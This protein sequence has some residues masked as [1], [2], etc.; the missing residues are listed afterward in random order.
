[1][2]KISFLELFERANSNTDLYVCAAHKDWFD[3]VLIYSYQ[4]SFLH[5]STAFLLG[6][7]R[8][9][10]EYPYHIMELKSTT[11]TIYPTF[12]AFLLNQNKRISKMPEAYKSLQDN[13]VISTSSDLFVY[14]YKEY[15]CIIDK[16]SHVMQYDQR[17]EF[18]CINHNPTIKDWNLFESIDEALDS[19]TEINIEGNKKCRSQ[20][21]KKS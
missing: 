9:I 11:T 13:T 4:Y 8:D 14:G 10:K 3:R 6:Q 5:K 16:L 17:D 19:M 20:P 1:M 2:N 15:I 12:R 7:I 21:K 18:N